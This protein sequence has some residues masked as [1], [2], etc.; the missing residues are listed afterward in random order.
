MNTER[1]GV[2]L[3]IQSEYGKIRTRKISVFEHFS[4]SVKIIERF[5]D[6]FETPIFRVYWSLDVLINSITKAF[7]KFIYNNSIP[8]KM[9]LGI[10]NDFI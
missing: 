5:L 3:R 6:N 9:F 4:R 7:S 10:T 1:C 2:S 8:K